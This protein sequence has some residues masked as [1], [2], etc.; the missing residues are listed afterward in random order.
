MILATVALCLLPTQDKAPLSFWEALAA[1]KPYLSL[2]YR[3]EHVDQNPFDVD[4]DAS[5]LRSVL[6]YKT[7]AF[8]PLQAL[9]EFESVAP[10]GAEN[11]NS[12]INGMTDHPVVADPESAEVNQVY[13]DYRPWESLTLRSGRQEIALDNERFIGPV[14]WR[15]NHQSFDAATL[16]WSAPAGIETFYGFLY[17]VNRIFGEEHPLG[18][19]RMGAHLLHAERAFEGLGRASLYAYLLDFDKS[20]ALAT[21]T[22]GVRWRGEMPVGEDF[23]A[24]STLEYALQRDAADNPGEVDADYYALELGASRAWLTARLGAEH[25]GGSGDPGDKFSTPLAT[26]HAFNGYAD[27]FL[28]TPDTG[29]EDRYAGLSARV[30]EDAV[31]NATY[32]DFSSDAGSLDYGSELDLDLAYRIGEHVTLGLKLA[33]FSGDQGFEDVTKAM[34]WA[35]VGVF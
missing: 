5:T 14:G 29:L 8:G 7:G 13:L 19:E 30:G 34:G 18:D 20:E 16:R 27:V 33:D 1:G 23:K 11:Y 17:Q 22:A 31:V 28:T 15:Q 6:G 26:L 2:R 35:T 24:A 4:A 10:V 3:F 9:V 12:T 25:L 21:N 32:H